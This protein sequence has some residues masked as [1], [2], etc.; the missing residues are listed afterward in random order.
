MDDSET[1]ARCP[2][3]GADELFGPLELYPETGMGGGHVLVSTIRSSP[4][5]ASTASAI[6]VRA[7]RRCGFLAL[8]ADEPER[9]YARWSESDV[10][11][12]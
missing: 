11:R 3:C 8:F 10:R 4:F 12:R 2:A 6:R 9:L 5:G 7:C 1:P